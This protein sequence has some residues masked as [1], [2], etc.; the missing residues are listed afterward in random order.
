LY[1]FAIKTYGSHPRTLL[2][3]AEMYM[4]WHKYDEA[5]DFAKQAYEADD[6]LEKAK[7]IVDKMGKRIFS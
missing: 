2:H 6:S 4:D 1:K 7:E 3:M 5:Y